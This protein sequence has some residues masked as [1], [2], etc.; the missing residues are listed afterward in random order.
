[1]KVISSLSTTANKKVAARQIFL[2][3]PT[4]FKEHKAQNK[5]N[6]MRPPDIKLLYAGL[7]FYSHFNYFRPR[8]ERAVDAAH[9]NTWNLRE[10]LHNLSTINLT[11]F[12][13]L[14]REPPT[15]LMQ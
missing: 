4:S 11:Q 5:F 8:G 12:Q 13:P 14:M 1:M 15:N 10:K 2:S 3:F 6:P 9:T 7:N